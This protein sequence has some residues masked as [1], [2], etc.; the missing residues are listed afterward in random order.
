MKILVVEDQEETAATLKT[1]LESECYAVDVEHD[2]LKASYRAKTN[3]YDL[4]LLDNM[5]PG[6]DGDQICKELREYKMTTPILIL[7]GQNDI[8]RK[9]GLLNCGADDYVTKPYSYTELSARVKA[10][11]R[12]PKSIESS[13]L[14]VGDL[15]LDR[16]MFSATRGKHTIKLTP[17]EYSI[18][19]YFM[20]NP[21]RVVTRGMILEHVWDDSADPLSNSI[22][23]HVT[24]L[25]KKIDRGGK[26]KLIRTIPGRGYTMGPS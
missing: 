17:K 6:K 1:R 16:E 24:N 14:T 8:E 13:T 11:L 19:E 21:G 5:L 15:V 3:H 23:T 7:S 26:R 12:R 22:E 20:K 4:I 25:R 2:G 10:L 9:V 18:L